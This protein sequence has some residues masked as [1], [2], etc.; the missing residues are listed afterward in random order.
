MRTISKYYKS[1]K[2]AERYQ[3]R[4]YNKYDH[5]RLIRAPVFTEDGVYVWEV[6]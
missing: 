3:N 4:L 1:M 6:K 2:Q 5:V